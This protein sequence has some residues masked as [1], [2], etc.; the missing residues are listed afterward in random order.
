MYDR[1]G[2]KMASMINFCL[3]LYHLHFDHFFS[4]PP[5]VLMGLFVH[6]GLLSCAHHYHYDCIWGNGCCI[7]A[8][9]SVV[10]SASIWCACLMVG[11]V[12]G[13]EPLVE[14]LIGVHLASVMGLWRNGFVNGVRLCSGIPPEE[15]V[16]EVWRQCLPNCYQ[17]RLLSR[18]GCSQGREKWKEC[19]YFERY[20]QHH[21]SLET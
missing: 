12:F 1:H 20:H 14:P 11:V 19:V 7:V 4:C 5:R 6:R 9:P 2:G 17:L 16:V 10:L 13:G 15:V 21:R 8:V 18:L 3:N